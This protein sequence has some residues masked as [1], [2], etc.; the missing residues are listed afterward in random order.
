MNTQPTR[1]QLA[2]A[3]GA[4]SSH[5]I[6]AKLQSNE[7]TALGRS[8]AEEELVR[9]E[10]E[11]ETEPEIEAAAFHAEYESASE[12]LRRPLGW[13]WGLWLAVTSICVLVVA[14]FGATARNQADQQ[15]LYVVIIVQALALAGILRAVMAVFSSS[16]ALGVLGK[17]AVV[18][19]LGYVLFALTLCSG[20]AQHGWGGG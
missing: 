9:R 18:G 20:M 3:I 19:A 4:L 2:L 15:F 12:L 16:S 17:V 7:L 6:R 8:V 13:S 11:G 1:E 14:G 10:N 5:A